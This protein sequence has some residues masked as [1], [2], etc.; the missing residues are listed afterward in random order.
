MKKYLLHFRV[1]TLISACLAALLQVIAVLTIYQPDSHYFD[2]TSILPSLAVFVAIVGAICGTV[3]AC[4]TERQSLNDTPF[5]RNASRAPIAVGF[6]APAILLP[7]SE[8]NVNSVLTIAIVAIS[9]IAV[10]YGIL[11]NVPPLAQKIPTATVLTGFAAVIGC[12]ALNAYY[13]FDM[14]LEMNSPL[15]VS[16][17]MGLLFATLYLTGELRYLL[18]VPMPRTFLMLGAWLVSIGA[19]SAFAIPVAYFAGL[20]N[21]DDYM[22]GAILVLCILLTALARAFTLLFSK[23]QANSEQ[24]PNEPTV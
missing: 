4:M 12:V 13:Y 15:K 3:A 21:R 20:T 9:G 23:S 24:T 17:Q 19:L 6:L 2:Q 11:T 18:G 16:V 1:A 22:A 14:T 8:F 5:S 7:N 10:V